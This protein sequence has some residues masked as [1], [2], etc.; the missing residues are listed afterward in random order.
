M[1]KRFAG[2]VAT[3][4]VAMWVAGSAAR[5]TVFPYAMNLTGPSE[6][7]ANASP[8]IG[9][10]TVTYDDAAHTLAISMSFSGLT[11]TTSAAHIHAPT[12]ASGLGSEAMASAAMNANV[13]TTAPSFVGF[14]LGVTSGVFVSVLDLTQASSYRAGYITDN[15]GTT[16]T[17]EAAL[18]SALAQGRAYFNVHTSTFGGGEIRG[19]P[20]LIPEPTSAVL[21]G[22]GLVCFGAVRRRRK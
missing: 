7:P 20:F 8:G 13:A 11:G 10:G 21:A 12:V 15:G 2:L 14:P 1:K 16:A 6:F 17:A 5:A 22:F 3:L 4:A 19:F 18:T 9:S